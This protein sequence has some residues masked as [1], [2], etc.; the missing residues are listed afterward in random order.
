MRDGARDGD[1]IA[2]VAT[3]PGAGGVGIV[4]VSGPLAARI[5]TQLTG[6]NLRP[7]RVEVATFR[8]AHGAPL[9]HG[10]ALLFVAPRSFTGE[11]VLEL[12]AH[13]SP[14]VLALLLDACVALGA[15]R[16]RAGEFSERA[17]LNDRLDL[18]QAEAVADLVAS[19]SEAQARAAARSMAVSSGMAD[20]RAASIFVCAVMTP[21]LQSKY[22]RIMAAK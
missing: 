11:D 18:A 10:V 7:R 5:A 3:A 21:F 4:R 1:T 19:T 20:L 15:R 16:A 22:A 8:D 13:G 14:V 17:F 12:Q 2:A 9:D 6:R